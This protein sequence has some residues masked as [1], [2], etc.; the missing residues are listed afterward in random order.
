MPDW[1]FGSVR[2]VDV[3]WIGTEHGLSGQVNRVLARTVDGRRVTFILK[4]E[5][6]AGA[7]R[8]MAFRGSMG[9]PT[10]PINS[11]VLRR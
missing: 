9:R 8:A 6:A 10:A 2:V 5:G 11:R 4:Q 1:P 7:E 3:A